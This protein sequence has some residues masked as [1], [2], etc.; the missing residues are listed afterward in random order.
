MEE[1]LMEPVPMT[2]REA[3]MLNPLQLAYIGDTVWD[4]LIRT[5]LVYTGNNVHAMH[6]MASS[7]VNAGAQAELLAA[8]LPNLTQ[9]ELALVKRGRNTRSKHPVPKNQDAADYGH[10]TGFEALIGFL[11]LTGDHQ[12]IK[13][14]YLL[15]EEH[16]AS[17]NP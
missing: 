9:E 13:A 14:L 17:K 1:L 10:A 12:R 16:H 11:Y 2:Q 8:L 4:L 3:L 6:K 15:G 7:R 5:A